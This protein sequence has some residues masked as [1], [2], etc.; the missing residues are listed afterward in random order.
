MING[1]LSIQEITRGRRFSR[2]ARHIELLDSTT[3]TNDHAWQA[4]GPSPRDGFVVLAE[5]QT[6]GRGRMGRRWI[7]PRGAGINCTVMIVDSEPADLQSA[8]RFAFIAGIAIVDAIADVTGIVARLQW[9]ND[10]RINRRKVAGIL[11][12]SRPMQ[13]RGRGYVLGMGINC[14]QQLRHFPPDLRSQATSLD[15]ESDLPVDR[16]RLTGAL[17]QCLD[18]WLSTGRAFDPDA[19]RRHYMD[20]LEPLGEPIRLRSAGREHSGHVVDVAADTSLVVQLD[21]GGRMLFPIN[22]TTVIRE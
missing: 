17:L 20:R 1:R 3:S 22:G 5:H 10:V 7:S 6:A 12:E 8:D 18:D 2:I 16:S 21:L 9:P 14:L 15:L 13:P 11:V 19:V 4:A